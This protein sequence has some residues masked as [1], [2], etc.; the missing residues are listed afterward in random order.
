MSHAAI[1]APLDELE[2]LVGLE[3]DAAQRRA[4]AR[5][6]AERAR[7][8]VHRGATAELREYADD[9][10]Y[11]RR[12]PDDEFHRRL[13]AEFGRRVGERGLVLELDGLRLRVSDP[14]PRLAYEAAV[15]HHRE[16]QRAVR[17][18]E[19]DHAEEIAAA[20]NA[21]KMDALRSAIAGDDPAAVRDA[22][23]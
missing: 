6:S 7:R 1:E 4:A 9:V 13:S 18:F 10:L 12:D 19:R 14:E 11:K 15:L 22:L 2:R 21:E 23:A 16:A 17:T 3:R 5:A 20:K 8:E